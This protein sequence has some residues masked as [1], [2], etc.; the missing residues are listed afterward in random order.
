MW[1]G[2]RLNVES[3]ER[4][5]QTPGGLAFVVRVADGCRFELA[6]DASKDQWSAR[7]L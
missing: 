3:V 7:S 5:W 4:A 1:H 2:E 6:Y